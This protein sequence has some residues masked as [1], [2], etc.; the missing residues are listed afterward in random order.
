MKK[1]SWFY[2]KERSA[3]KHEDRQR[4][5]TKKRSVEMKTSQKRKNDGIYH[6]RYF[7]KCMQLW[8]SVR[9]QQYLNMRTLSKQGI[10]YISQSEWKSSSMNFSLLLHRMPITKRVIRSQQKSPAI[11]QERENTFSIANVHFERFNPKLQILHHLN[12]FACLSIIEKIL[13]ESR[14]RLIYR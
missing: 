4:T 1:S 7:L 13:F 2:Q 3:E 8:V 11:C 10:D 9:H 14:S 5:F 12:S 6:W